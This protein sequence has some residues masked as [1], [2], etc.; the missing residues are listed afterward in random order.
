MSP[1]YVAFLVTVLYPFIAAVIAIIIPHLIHATHLLSNP[2]MQ[3]SWQIEAMCA[4]VIAEHWFI[5][6]AVHSA[7]QA[8]QYS[9]DTRDRSPATRHPRAASALPNFI[10]RRPRSTPEELTERITAYLNFIHADV[11]AE[12]AHELQVEAEVAQLRAALK[13]AIKCAKSGYSSN[14]TKQLEKL[15][16]VLVHIPERWR[17]EIKETRKCWRNPQEVHARLNDVLAYL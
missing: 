6:E 4:A 17:D 16:R 8:R 9:P 15:T 14:Q 12:Y 5:N 2:W 1:S 3:E 10:V 7:P 11:V 13:H